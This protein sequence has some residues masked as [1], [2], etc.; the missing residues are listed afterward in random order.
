MIVHK[1]MISSSIIERNQTQ[2]DDAAMSG[3]SLIVASIST[4]LAITALLLS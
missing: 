4:V 1:T 3:K 2:L